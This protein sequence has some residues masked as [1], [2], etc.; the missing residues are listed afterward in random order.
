MGS[1]K[2]KVPRLFGSKAESA[3][4]ASSDGMHVCV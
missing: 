2:A 1:V 4:S 3:V